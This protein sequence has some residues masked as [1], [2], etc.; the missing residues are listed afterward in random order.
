MI[1]PVWCMVHGVYNLFF[2][3]LILFLL[4]I[5]IIIII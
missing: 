2:N 4:F 5:I 3:L 1:L